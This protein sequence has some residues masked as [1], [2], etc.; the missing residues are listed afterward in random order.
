MSAET[1]TFRP[2]NVDDRLSESLSQAEFSYGDL[3]C[4]VGERILIED[5]SFGMRTPT[6]SWS[7]E[8]QFEG[9]KRDLAT[10]AA[11][12]GIDVSHL[13]LMVIARSSYLKVSEVVYFHPLAEL[14]GIDREIRLGESDDGSRRHAFSTETHCATVDA[15]VT[16]HRSLPTAPLRP[17]QISTWLAHASFRVKRESDSTL[18]RPRPLDNENRDR[19]RL[20]KGVTRYIEFDS[21]ELTSSVSG[22]EIPTYWVDEGL[23]TELDRLRNSPMAA[24]LQLQLA[25]DFVGG[26]SPGVLTSSG[27]RRSKRRILKSYLRGHQRLPARHGSEIRSGIACHGHPA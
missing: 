4:G 26:C 14:K 3:R 5:Q 11:A 17:S 18:Y 10:G 25:L 16:L 27:C 12:T 7:P 6:L 24:H 2:F 20:K 1:R 22:S 8:H 21:G 9:F 19:L 13:C 15:F 23:V